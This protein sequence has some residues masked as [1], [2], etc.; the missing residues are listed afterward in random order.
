MAEFKPHWADKLEL[1]IDR[2]EYQKLLDKPTKQVK[3]MKK[4]QNRK[5]KEFTIQKKKYLHLNSQRKN[6]VRKNYGDPRML[7]KVHKWKAQIS[8]DDIIYKLLNIQMKKNKL[9]NS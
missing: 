6:D 4:K 3:Q 8:I 7:F 2:H 1:T 5:Y 9:I